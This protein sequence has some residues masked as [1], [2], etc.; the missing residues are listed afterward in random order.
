MYL[1]DP[2]P[3]ILCDKRISAGDFRKQF[4][5]VFLLPHMAR[6]LQGERIQ[7]TGMYDKISDFR[8]ERKKNRL[9]YQSVDVGG[10]S[11]TS[12]FLIVQHQEIEGADPPL[13]IIVKDGN[14]LFLQGHPAKPVVAFYFFR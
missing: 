5:G 10:C 2:R 4:L 12:F 8:A 6:L 7:K 11:K 13:R 1:L 3:L 9:F 14:L